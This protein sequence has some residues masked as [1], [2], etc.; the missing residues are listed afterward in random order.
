MRPPESF[1]HEAGVHVPAR[2]AA[3]LM[4]SRGGN[5]EAARP[6]GAGDAAAEIAS[7]LEALRGMGERWR[8]AQ[9]VPR[10]GTVRAGT[11]ERPAVSVLTTQKAADQL[12]YKTTRAI[13]KA[14][15]EKRLLAVK[16]S[17]RWQVHPRDL[18]QM[19]SRRT[20]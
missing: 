15:A 9:R 5:L 1:M 10:E 14:I 12:G 20:P 11:S 7:V 18:D 19:R 16:V 8:A 4:H 6:G 17:G 2:V 3:W 13:T